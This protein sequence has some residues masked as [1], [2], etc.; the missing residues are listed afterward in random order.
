MKC[1]ICG[2]ELSEPYRTVTIDYG[3]YYEKY[4]LCAECLN[5]SY[6]IGWSAYYGIR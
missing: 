4:Y 1:E 6:A 2:K 5:K 3:N